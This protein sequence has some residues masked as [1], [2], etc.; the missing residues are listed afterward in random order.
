MTNTDYSSQI[1]ELIEDLFL[2]LGFTEEERKQ[3]AVDLEKAVFDDLTLRLVD[4]LP[5]DV[6]NELDTGIG[7]VETGEAKNKKFWDICKTH[8]GDEQITKMLRESLGDVL[9]Q[10]ASGMIGGL[11]PEKREIITDFQKKRVQVMMA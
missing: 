1:L 4:K 3:A 7:T 8:Y 6:Q 10:Y 11:V 5:D 2:K 9:S